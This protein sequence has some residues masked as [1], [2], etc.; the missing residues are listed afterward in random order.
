MI[1]GA[2]SG[3]VAEGRVASG[4][5]VGV[6]DG[7]HLGYVHFMKIVATPPVCIDPA[8]RE[9]IE[10]ALDEG[11]SLACIAETAVRQ[12]ITRCEPQSEFLRRGIAAIDRTAAAG[13]GIA[14]SS[15]I[16]RLEAKLAEA[17]K[18]RPS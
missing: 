9:E 11:D 8:S 5:F 1:R 6:V 7:S 10:Q 17:R 14:P 4:R 3:C 2:A 15:V 12:E 18:A 16:A 13:D